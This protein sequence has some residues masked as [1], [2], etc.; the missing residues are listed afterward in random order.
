MVITDRAPTGASDETFERYARLAQAYIGAPVALVSFVDDDVVRFPGARG[1]IDGLEQHRTIDRPHSYC[2]QVVA[3]NAPLVIEDARAHPVYRKHLATCDLNVL[4]YAGYPLHDID[5]QAVGALCA[6]DEEPRQ[7]TESDLAILADLAKSCTTE[8][9]LRGEAARAVDARAHAEEMADYTQVMLTLSESFVNTVLVD[10][11]VAAIAH[12]ASSIVGVARTAVCLLAPDGKSLYWP[13]HEPIDSVPEALWTEMDMAD[14]RFP[15]VVAVRDREPIFLA[16]AH[17]AAVEYPMLAKIGADRD[18]IWILP[19]TTP[20]T[21]YGAVTLRWRDAAPLAVGLREVVT[22]LAAYAAL[23]L[24]RAHLLENRREVASILQ[25]AMLTE[26]PRPR[27]LSVDAAYAPAAAGEQVGGDWYDV[28]ERPDGS[29]ALVVGDVTGHDIT[30]ASLMGQV[31]SS[32]RTLLWEHE[33]PP[34]AVLHR[35]DEVL[36]GTRVGAIATIV[37]VILAPSGPDGSRDLKWSLAGHPPPLV[38]RADGS[39]EFLRLTPG[40]PVGID[41]DHRR[42]DGTVRIEPGDELVLYTDGLVEER[43]TP[44]WESLE[45]LRASV[46]G[47]RPTGAHELLDRMVPADKR[48]DDVVVLTAGIEG[49]ENRPTVE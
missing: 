43:T 11:V 10:D 33:C 13:V 15:A 7:W 2:P 38:R 36:V 26:L 16:T 21:V 3:Q 20:N 1:L 22:A 47:R 6:I 23:A 8:I 30:A 46:E 48:A 34:S 5:G 4:A 28:M 31:R 12:S 35:L 27:G 44:L 18:G 17:D 24:E 14:G 49:L 45:A 9:C 39:A 32:L 19:L 40:L 37:L 25:A 41:T 42:P 29:V